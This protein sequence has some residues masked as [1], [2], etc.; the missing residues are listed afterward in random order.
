MKDTAT[1]KYLAAA[2]GLFALWVCLRYLLPL[3]M[4][5]LIGTLI[6]LAAEPI[7]RSLHQQTRLPRTAAACLGVG[8]ACTM[9][10][11][12]L[13]IL[14][15]LVVRELR[16]AA[17]VVPELLRM[18]Q[19]GLGQLEQWLLSLAARAPE[20]AAG[21]L[22]ARIL[23]LFSGGSALLDRAAAAV[24]NLAANMLGQ[25]PGGA[26]GLGTAILSGFMISVKL[27]KLRAALRRVIPPA[28]QQRCVPLLGNIRRAVVGW[29]KAQAALA[30]ITFT[31]V[32]SGLFLLRVA[33]AP[34]IG[35]VVALVDAVPLLGT[36]TVMLPWALIALLQQDPA[37]AVGLLGIYAAAA[38]TRS[39]LEPRFVGKQLGL[40]PLVTLAAMYLGCRLW[41]VLGIL[42]S[43]IAAVTVMQVLRTPLP[44]AETRRKKS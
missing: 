16:T 42:L 6:A 23:Q 36:G 43:P 37:R 17:G 7:V 35:A 9:G 15:A 28:V 22:K 10:A 30:G 34:L 8:I 19:Q 38:L 1:R 13:L 39:V 27:P 32:T 3:M 41:G 26:L 44:E 24:L 31:I 21:V 33:Y 4:P 29:L 11:L 14:S 2:G 18:I 40:D 5:F 12:V 20:D 25:L